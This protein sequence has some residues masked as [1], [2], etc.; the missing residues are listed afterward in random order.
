MD[1]KNEDLMNIYRDHLRPAV[2]E[3]GYE[4][5]ILRDVLQAGVIDNQLRIEIIK[6]RFL[7]VDLSDDNN[8]AYWEAGFA[9]GLGRPVI[10]LCEKNKFDAEKP[11]FDTNHCTTVIYEKNKIDEAMVE[12]KATIRATLPSETIM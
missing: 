6:S 3:T 9:E 12:L 7:L 8:G 10:Y 2:G 11:H 1:Y 5:R 4:L